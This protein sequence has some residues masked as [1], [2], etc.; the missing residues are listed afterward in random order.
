MRSPFLNFYGSS[1]TFPLSI[2]ISYSI[3][4]NSIFIQKLFISV[5]SSIN[6]C[7]FLAFYAQNRHLFIYN[8]EYP[9]P[10]TMVILKGNFHL[11]KP[12]ISINCITV[13]EVSNLCRPVT[14]YNK[15]T[16][17]FNQSKVLSIT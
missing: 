8:F 13:E 9:Y 12:N 6:K 5:S 10:F 14:E 15:H 1:I 4:E 16:L 11:A 7:L 2:F 17:F 3:P